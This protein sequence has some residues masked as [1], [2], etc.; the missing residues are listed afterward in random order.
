V[1]SEAEQTTLLLDRD[2]LVLAGA[3]VAYDGRDVGQEVGAELSGVTDAARRATRHLHSAVDVDRV[4][5]RGGRRGDDAVRQRR[6]PRAGH[7]ARDAARAVRRLLDRVRRSCAPLARAAVSARPF[8]SIL[9][10]LTRQR[11]VTAALV[12]SERDGIVVESNL[13]IGQSADRVAAL[14]ASLYRKARQSARA[15]GPGRRLVHAARGAR[16]RCAVGG[17]DLVLVVVAEPAVNVGLVRV[18]L[19]RAVGELLAVGGADEVA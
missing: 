11:W 4:R 8:A 12:V 5:D 19:L 1:L 17:G 18:E 7:I 14:A 16:R 9:D 13:Q 2:G 10:T 6:A 15:A 3:Y